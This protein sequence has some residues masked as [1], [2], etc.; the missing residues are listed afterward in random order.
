MI[1]RVI[2]F[3]T[4]SSRYFAY[5]LLTFRFIEGPSRD[6]V[7]WNMIRLFFKKKKIKLP[8]HLMQKNTLNV[9]LLTQ[10]TITI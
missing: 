8:I 4:D 3:E 5:L 7:Y 6:E 2:V 1:S 10:L 9:K